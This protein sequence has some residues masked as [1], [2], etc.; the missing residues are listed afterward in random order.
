M[1]KKVLLY[2]YYLKHSYLLIEN[3]KGQ[4]NNPYII[5]LLKS[6]KILL[7]N[8]LELLHYI[9]ICPLLHYINSK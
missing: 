4:I 1:V 7:A 9:Y 5:N 8:H 3:R 6:F 2:Q